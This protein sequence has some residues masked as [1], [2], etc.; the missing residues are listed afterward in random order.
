MVRAL[1]GARMPFKVA[2]FEGLFSCPLTIKP[3]P[4]KLH[5]SFTSRQPALQSSPTL[6]VS[7]DIFLTGCLGFSLLPVSCQEW[8]LFVIVVESLCCC[9]QNESFDYFVK[10]CFF[11]I[12][13]PGKHHNHIEFREN[14]NFLSAPTT[15][16][17]HICF[18]A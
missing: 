11:S 18:L 10:M 13:S 7:P 14:H 5:R 12:I 17:K 1:L 4:I 9:R 3:L 2:H 15:S 8:M 6:K 16:T